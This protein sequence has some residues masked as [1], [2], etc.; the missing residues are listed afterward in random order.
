MIVCILSFQMPK[1]SLTN[2]NRRETKHISDSNVPPPR[3]RGAR[4]NSP[5]R[6]EATHHEL[7]LEQVEHDDEY[8]DSLSRPG[9]EFCRTIPGAS[10]PRT[11]ARTSGLK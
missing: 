7:E 2:L 4:L 8:L 5:N 6:F 11:T 3:G 1:E 10:S 9:T